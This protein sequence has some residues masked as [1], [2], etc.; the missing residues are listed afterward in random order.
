MNNQ[1]S[2]RAMG[3]IEQPLTLRGLLIIFTPC[4]LIY[5][6]NQHMC[7]DLRAGHNL[8]KKLNKT[9]QEGAGR[10]YIKPFCKIQNNPKQN[11]G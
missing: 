9:K 6:L 4:L 11:G 3:F 8:G 1:K 7:A 2:Y 5:N 10:S